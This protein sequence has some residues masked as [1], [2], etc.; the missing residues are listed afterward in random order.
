M[1]DVTGLINCHLHADHSGQNAAFPGI[2]TWV[3]PAE[4]A[5]AHEPDHTI[6]EWVDYEGADI[7][8]AAGDH[9]VRPGVRVLATPGHTPGHQSVAVDTDD[10]LV[11]LAGQAC[12]T[13][14]EWEGDPDALEGRSSAPT[15][16]PTT[17]RS[18]ACA[19][20]SR[21]ASCSGTTATRGSPRG[22]C[23]RRTRR[24]CGTRGAHRAV[25]PSR[26]PAGWPYRSRLAR[27]AARRYPWRAVLGGELAVPCS[28]QSAPAG[29]N[30][31]SRS[32]FSVAARR[33][34]VEDRVPRSDEPRTVSGPEGSSTKRPSAGAAERPD[35][36][37]P[38]WWARERVDRRRVHG[39][40]DPH[41][42]DRRW[43]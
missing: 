27:L 10:G 23:S 32:P 40:P 39:T 35:P 31:L 33:C 25:A 42:P 12:Y 29:L 13:A 2:P 1:A 9:L 17:A 3:Q 16:S 5:A 6:V 4:W 34:D 43:W 22:R 38:S 21:R 18:N 37:R 26:W 14:G 8:E 7:R 28:L 30:P 15:G 19:A 36:S 11:I 20:C 24:P 41:A